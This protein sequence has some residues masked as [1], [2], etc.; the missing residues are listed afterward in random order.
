MHTAPPPWGPHPGCPSSGH[1]GCL[2]RPVLLSQVFSPERTSKG[3]QVHVQPIHRPLQQEIFSFE[4]SGGLPWGGPGP[5][6]RLTVGAGK[7]KRNVCGLELPGQQVR[8]PQGGGQE[9]MPGTR[10]LNVGGSRKNRAPQGTTAGAT[11]WQNSDRRDSWEATGP[12]YLFPAVTSLSR[13]ATGNSCGTQPPSVLGG[14]WPELGERC[15]IYIGLISPAALHPLCFSVFAVY[16]IE[17][18]RKW[19]T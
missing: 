18:L 9:R 13:E 4:L 8:V 15:C 6:S 3:P 14:H 7:A 5:G 11:R 12:G 17:S 2:R 16:L 19:E 1:S 10:P